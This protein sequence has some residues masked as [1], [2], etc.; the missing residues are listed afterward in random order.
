MKELD[1]YLQNILHS[2]QKQIAQDVKGLVKLTV[3]NVTG[4]VKFEI[5]PYALADVT[6]ERTASNWRL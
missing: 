3:Q 5:K 6:A 1:D 2:L 4:A